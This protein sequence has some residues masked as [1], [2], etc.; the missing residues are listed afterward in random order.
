MAERANNSAVVTAPGRTLKTIGK[1][2]TITSA[3]LFK[4]SPQQQSFALNRSNKMASLVRDDHT[5]SKAEWELIGRSLCE[6]FDSSQKS[7]YPHQCTRVA[8]RNPIQS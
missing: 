5:F 3:M 8:G 1:V 7:K 6:K 2:E 4:E